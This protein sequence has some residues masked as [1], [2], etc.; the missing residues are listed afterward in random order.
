MINFNHLR[1]FH[2]VY[3]AGSVTAAAR[4]LRISQPAVSK[5]LAALEDA[6]GVRLFDRR[7]RGVDATSAGQLLM[8]HAQRIFDAEIAAEREL[9]EHRGLRRGQL[10]V[11]ASTTIGSYLAPRVFG[12]FRRLHPGVELTLDIGNTSQVEQAVLTG[13]VDLGLSEGFVH[14]ER[15]AV[16][17]FVHDEVVAIIAPG[18]PLAASAPVSAKR[19][20]ELPFLAREPGSG[21]RAVVEAE[22]RRAGLTLEPA[23]SLGSTEALK[24]AV[25]SGLG[26]SMLS[27]L[28]V[29]LECESGRLTELP[30]TDLRVRRALNQLHLADRSPSPAAREFTR[31]LAQISNAE[32]NDQLPVS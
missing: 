14:S 8:V 12:H 29:Q 4:E 21:T 2:G 16:D 7:A 5:S 24:S 11:A 30:L 18:H 26:V 17:V 25:A 9:A 22:F 20:L 27:R 1:I 19:L 15:L 31:L 10:Q 32:M 23:M 6:V 3:R 13:Q 28:A